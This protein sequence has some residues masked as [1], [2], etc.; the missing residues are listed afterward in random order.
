MKPIAGWS[1][2]TD[3]KQ[4]KRWTARHHVSYP[5]KPKSYPCFMKTVFD[6]SSDS[7]TDFLYFDDVEKMTMTFL[8]LTAK[9][10]TR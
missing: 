7:T 8:R 2:V 9:R 6:S 5:G 1:L 4:F 3:E 10:K